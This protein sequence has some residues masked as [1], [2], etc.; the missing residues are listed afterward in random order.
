LAL[1]PYLLEV[2]A[3]GRKKMSGALNEW[4]PRL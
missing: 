4:V 2:K 3:S 1:L